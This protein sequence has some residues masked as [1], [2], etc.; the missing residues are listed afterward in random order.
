L[1]VPASTASLGKLPFE[2]VMKDLNSSR[3]WTS[4]TMK[5]WSQCL[6][7]QLKPV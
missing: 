3:T 4:K 1:K 6:Y 5:F 2:A 7:P